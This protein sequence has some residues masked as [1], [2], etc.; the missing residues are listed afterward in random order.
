MVDRVGDMHVK[1]N[2]DMLDIVNTIRVLPLLL[3]F[4]LQQQQINT[5]VAV[6][7]LELYRSIFDNIILQQIQQSNAQMS[8]IVDAAIFFNSEL[9]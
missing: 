4:Q 6:D 3:D 9:I 8:E 2:D 5:Q 7:E 1:T